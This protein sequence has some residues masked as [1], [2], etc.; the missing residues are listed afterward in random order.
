MIR[1]PQRTTQGGSSAASDVYKVQ[2]NGDDVTGFG[3]MTFAKNILEEE[4]A[5]GYYTPSILLGPNIVESLPGFS[6][7]EYSDN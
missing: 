6:G 1:R 4:F 3:G 5:G 2:A 7:I